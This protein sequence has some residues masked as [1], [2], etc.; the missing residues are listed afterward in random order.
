LTAALSTPG[1]FFSAFSTRA[2]Q[3][4]QV[5]PPTPRSRV[6]VVEVFMAPV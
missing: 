3:L 6:E 4:A 1:T 5:M 2:T